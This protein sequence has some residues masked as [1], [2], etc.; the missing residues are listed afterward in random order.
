MQWQ[1]IEILSHVNK[2]VKNQREIGL[3][4]T[5]LWEIYTGANSTPMVKNFCIMYIEMA[6]ERVQLEVCASFRAIQRHG[7]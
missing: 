2:R 4:L 3:P 7:S 5:E 6:F 1:V